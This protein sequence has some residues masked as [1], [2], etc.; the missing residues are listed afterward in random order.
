MVVEHLTVIETAQLKEYFSRLRDIVDLLAGYVEIDK[1]I[2]EIIEEEDPDDWETLEECQHR[3]DQAE[4]VIAT[5][6]GYV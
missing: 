5:A 3:V 1:R 2:I 6:R 4:A